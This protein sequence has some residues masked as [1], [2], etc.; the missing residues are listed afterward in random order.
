MDT[1]FWLWLWASSIICGAVAGSGKSA[2]F[3]G[4]LLG[5]FC[6]PLGVIAALGIDGRVKCPACGGRLDSFTKHCQ[7]CATPLS[8]P[9]GKPIVC[10]PADRR[11]AET[12]PGA[13]ELP[14]SQKKSTFASA[15]QTSRP[16]NQ[17]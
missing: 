14:A 17:R 16:G 2:T 12:W 4:V 1:L 5:C 9:H 15:P 3:E 8:W 6:G 13:F 11:S 10:V 7:H